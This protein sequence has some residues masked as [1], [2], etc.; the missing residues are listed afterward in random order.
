MFNNPQQVMR[1]FQRNQSRMFNGQQPQTPPIN[2]QQF[3]AWVPQINPAMLNQLAAV[4]R[5]QGMSETDINAGINFI[6]DLR[7]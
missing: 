7:R 2:Q 4:A 5:S 6:Q 1:Q 3:I